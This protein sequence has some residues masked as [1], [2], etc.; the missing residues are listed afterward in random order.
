M[1]IITIS[2]FILLSFYAVN[3]QDNRATILQDLEKSQFTP[4][5]DTQLTAT[6]KSA[7]RLFGA[8]DDLTTVIL[9]IPADSIVEVLGSD[10]TYLNVVYGDYEGYIYKRDAEIKE[11]PAPPKPVARPEEVTSELKDEA[12][13]QQTSRFSYLENKYGTSMAA[14]LMSG[15]VW[16][17]MDAEMVRDSWGKPQKINR[18]IAGN[19]IKE[20][21]IYKSTWLYIEDDILVEWGAIR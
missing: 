10:S 13:P 11:A 4:P 20:E 16:K 15:K 18:V 7:S 8:K 6:L 19:T 5:Q 9:I 17:G 14:K 12:A 1:K 2:L 3:A 21:W